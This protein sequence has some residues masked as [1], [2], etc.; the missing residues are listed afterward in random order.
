MEKRTVFEGNQIQDQITYREENPRFALMGQNAA[1][2][3]LAW[4]IS[5]EMLS[6]H[7]LL[8]G[9]IGTGKSNVFY[10]LIRN[11]RETVGPKDVMFIFDTK[12]DY[13]KKFYRPGDIVLSN[14][15]RACGPAGKD[16]WNL[17]N[18]VMIDDRLEENIME[19]CKTLFAEKTERT[20]QPFFP[21]A[22]KDLLYALIL[23]I[24]RSPRGRDK[25]DNGSLRAALNDFSPRVMCDILKAYPDLKAMVSYIEDPSSPQT[26]GVASELQEAVREVLVG[27]FAR[28]GTLSMRD[29]VRRKGGRVVF[30]EYD[31]SIGGTLSPVYRLL[32][33]F[34]IKQ[35]LCRQED[36]GNVFFLLDEF[37]LLPLLQHIDDGVNF[38]RSLGAKFIVG[39]Q[40]I[41]QMEHAYGRELARSILA[42][43]ATTV[44][45][46]LNDGGSRAFVKEMLG[47][48]V[49]KLTFVS[50]VQNR[51]V[52]EQLRDANVAE[53]WD[54][55]SLG[56]GDAIVNYAQYPPFRIHFNRFS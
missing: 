39:V 14:D 18:E 43:F 2:Q 42:G 8:I 53:D 17:F 45:F 7:M 11:I 33:D 3:R 27:N 40:N 41:E 52:V 38:G 4:A 31:L 16:Y 15:S 37:R 36:E 29:I 26:L 20:N 54:I 46:R 51:G 55:T 35:A 47:K 1:G 34:A 12:G 6:R 9:G 23:H 48:N 21:N 44:C 28:R 10:H 13:Y 5:E 50:S 49:T 56:L 25:R 32:F 22:A 30:V 24:C 19:A